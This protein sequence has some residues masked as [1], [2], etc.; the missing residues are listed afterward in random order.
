MNYM[1]LVYLDEQGTPP[2]P[3]AMEDRCGG[4]SDRL[5]AS[6]ALLGAGILQPTATAT[7]V[8]IREGK[9]LVTDGP[10]AETREQLAGFMIFQ[11]KDLDEALAIA[12]QHPVAEWGTI[13]I[14]PVREL[15]MMDR[16]ASGSS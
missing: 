12:E 15:P 9:K 10:F 11:A 13:E 3:S 2:S 14:R 5:S 1:L 16:P 7:S 8:R 6:G 4:L